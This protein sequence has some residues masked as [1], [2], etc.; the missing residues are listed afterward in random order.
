MGSILD[1]QLSIVQLGVA[2]AS[3]W[4]ESRRYFSD[5]PRYFQLPALGET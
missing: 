2:Y 3:N 4:V 1:R 5:R